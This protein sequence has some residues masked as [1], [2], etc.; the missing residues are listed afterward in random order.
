MHEPRYTGDVEA[1][2][3]V[4]AIDHPD[5]HGRDAVAGWM[6]TSFE[7]FRFQ[8]ELRN[9][10][11]HAGADWAVMRGRFTLTA[12]PRGGGSATTLQGKHMVVWR[13]DESGTWKAWRD[14]W[15][16]APAGV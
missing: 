10:E 15:N 14:I 16:V 12:T 7:A 13:R 9:D 8:Q 5:L 11:V 3:E 2:R 6:R 4:E 1:A